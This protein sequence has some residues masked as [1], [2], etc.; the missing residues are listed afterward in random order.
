MATQRSSSATAGAR[1]SN[2]AYSTFHNSKK[3][4]SEAIMTG[5]TKRVVSFFS[6]SQC[7]SPPGMHTMGGQK[8]GYQMSNSAM[9]GR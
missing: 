8:T 6:A 4:H 7:K 5:P 9:S 3:P 1:L 2:V